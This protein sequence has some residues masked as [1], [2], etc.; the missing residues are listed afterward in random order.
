MSHSSDHYQG[1]LLEELREQMK[2]VIEALKALKDV[3]ADIK[4]IKADMAEMKQ[5]RFVAK[6]VIKDQSKTLNNHETRL[7]KLETA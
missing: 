7:I 1:V 4:Q 3:P 6:E 2:F 5:W